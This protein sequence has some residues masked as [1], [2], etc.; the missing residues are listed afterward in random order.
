MS[1]SPATKVYT[2]TRVCRAADV[3]QRVSPYLSKTSPIDI[4]DLWPNAGVLSSTIHNYLRPRRHLLVEPEL[5]SFEPWLQ[6][7]V[8]SDPSYKLISEE[9]YTRRDWSD[10]FEEHLQ[11]N[12]ALIRNKSTVNRC[13]GMIPSLSWPVRPSRLRKQ[14]TIRR[15]GGGAQ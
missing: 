12:R 5:P 7:L 10:V 4:L 3:L 2:L 14:T 8:D 6:Q 9:I 11:S 13:P 1:H 15:S